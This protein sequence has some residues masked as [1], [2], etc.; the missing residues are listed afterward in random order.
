MSYPV[1][2]QNSWQMEGTVSSSFICS[3]ATF[4]LHKAPCLVC[5]NI[6]ANPFIHWFHSPHFHQHENC[7]RLV[8]TWAC[9]FLQNQIQMIQDVADAAV[10]DSTHRDGDSTFAPHLQ[11]TTN[12]KI[13]KTP[14]FEVYI[15]FFWGLP[16]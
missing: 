11:I 10:A 6:S 4:G 13:G 2:H 15:L 14:C 5:L 16:S 1:E 12:G 8:V 3:Y 9:H 7:H